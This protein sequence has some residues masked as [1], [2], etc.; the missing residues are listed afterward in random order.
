[1][2]LDLPPPEFLQP[3]VLDLVRSNESLKQLI[4]LLFYTRLEIESSS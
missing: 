3:Y 2:A 4:K 1:M